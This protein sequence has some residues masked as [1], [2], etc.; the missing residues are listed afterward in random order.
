MAGYRPDNSNLVGVSLDDIFANELECSQLSKRTRV[1]VLEPDYKSFLDKDSKKVIEKVRELNRGQDGESVCEVD[2]ETQAVCETNPETGD[3][4]NREYRNPIPKG[5][6]LIDDAHDCESRSLAWQ[7]LDDKGFKRRLEHWESSGRETEKSI[8]ISYESELTTDSPGTL[9]ISKELFRSMCDI[10][11]IPAIFVKAVL[12]SPWQAHICGQAY[13]IESNPDTDDDGK[14]TGVTIFYHFQ[15]GL[16]FNRSYIF[17]RHHLESNTTTNICINCMPSAQT[18]WGAAVGPLRTQPANRSP[19]SFHVMLLYRILESLDSDA[20]KLRTKLLRHE[21]IQSPPTDL[22]LETWNLHHLAQNMHILAEYY[23]DAEAKV[24]FLIQA[25][26]AY[27]N[28][29]WVELKATMRED[30]SHLEAMRWRTSVSKRWIVDYKDRVGIRINH[31]FHVSNQEQAISMG[32][33]AALT[34]FF[35]PPTFVCSIFG[36]DVFY[37][38]GDSGSNLGGLNVSSDWWLYP[39]TAVPLTVVVIGIWILW[40]RTRL[41]RKSRRLPD[42]ESGRSGSYL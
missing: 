34:L 29:S 3:E 9:T 31:V 6:D 10:L 15:S 7:E 32:T 20:E 33:V 16:Q 23:A 27:Q 21:D 5:L 35:L 8:L 2:L 26:S 37:V 11:R 18:S 17:S 12:A 13:F 42:I 25:Y 24:E 4:R 14:I 19:F 39:A 36:M 22:A 28:S 1:S 40:R 30:L 38:S 41:K